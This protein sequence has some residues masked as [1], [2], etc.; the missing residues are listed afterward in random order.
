MRCDDR[1]SAP[2]SFFE[3]FEKIVARAS[4][5]RLEAEVVKANMAMATAFLEAL[6]AA[7][8]YVI[9]TVLT[10]NGIQLPIC[11]KT[12]MVQPSCCGAIRSSA[13]VG[14]TTLS[15]ASQSQITH[16]PMARSSA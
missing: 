2:V 8:P 15:I 3:D 11:R 16:G 12:V 7:V 5:E 9:H 10:D 6:I 1:R 13:P 14:D 4:V